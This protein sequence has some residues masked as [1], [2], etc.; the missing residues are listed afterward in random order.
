MLHRCYIDDAFGMNDRVPTT[1]VA[2]HTPPP[3]YGVQA[4]PEYP[5]LSLVSTFLSPVPGRSSFFSGDGN[6][7]VRLRSRER[8]A[9]VPHAQRNVRL[10]QALGLTGAACCGS[11]PYT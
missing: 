8:R 10:S 2:L 3:P 7:E 1:D 9:Q 4:Y 6:R 11:S 5:P